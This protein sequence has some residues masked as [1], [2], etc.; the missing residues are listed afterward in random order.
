M[1]C[2]CIAGSFWF[3]D[4]QFIY[5][6][7][8]F[9]IAC[10]LFSYTQYLQ[11]KK[12]LMLK[13]LSSIKVPRSQTAAMQLLQLYA[14][15]GHV[16]WTSGT[17]ERSKLERLVQKLTPF[18]IERDAPGRAYDKTKR[19]ASTHLVVLDAENGLLPW[20]LI[21]TAG[22]GGLSDPEAPNIGQVGDTRLA[23]QHLTW[24][25]YEL[26]HVEKIMTLTRDI[27]TKAGLVLKDRKS[28]L[29]TTTWTWRMTR[30]K[31]ASHEAFIV[32]LARQRDSGRL[33]TEVAALAMM[34]LFSG[35][36]GQVLK[37]HAEARKLA[38]KFKCDAPELP[39]LPCMVKLP[40]YAETPKTLYSISGKHA[41]CCLSA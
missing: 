2:L 39:Q 36:R 33:A 23:G 29:R 18:R 7:W 21:S 11:L 25:H 41:D 22:K 4:S 26:L 37:L 3:H 28:T 31:F 32:S 1:P 14:Q 15:S 24:T 10:M 30:D 38:A 6:M 13:L 5:A 40:I 20:V 9:L 19:L 27:K 12:A 34:P 17:V 8:L 35:V 16:F